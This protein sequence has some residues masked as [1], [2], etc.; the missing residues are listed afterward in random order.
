VVAALLFLAGPSLLR[1]YTDWLWFGEVGYRQV[2]TTIIQSE[3]S[4]FTI[5]FVVSV[6]WLIFNLRLALGS[7]GEGRPIFT[8]Q[9]GWEAPPPAA[10]RCRR[11]PPRSPM[12]SSEAA[13]GR[14]ARPPSLAVS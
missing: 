14:G 11:T 7:V 4:L 6:I 10:R 1:F 3:A 12:R 9:Q 8:T 2:F 13:G 5:A